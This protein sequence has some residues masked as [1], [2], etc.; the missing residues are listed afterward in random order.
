M[1]FTWLHED[2][3]ASFGRSVDR[4]ISFPSVESQKMKKYYKLVR[5]YFKNELSVSFKRH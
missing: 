2:S 3:S 4:K 1:C 5:K